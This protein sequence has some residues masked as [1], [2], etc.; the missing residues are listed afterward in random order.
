MLLVKK[1]HFFLDLSLVKKGLEIRFNDVLDRKETF[2]DHKNNIFQ[3]LK[4]RTF[5]KGLTHAFDQ[6]MFFFLNLFSVK[7]GLEIRFMMF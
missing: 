2:F 5:P 3:S 1:C 4:K 6:K 7:K